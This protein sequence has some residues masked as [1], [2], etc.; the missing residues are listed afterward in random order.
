M[1][2]EESSIQGVGAEM[3]TESSAGL[4]GFQSWKL[5]HILGLDNNLQGT[6]RKK[7]KH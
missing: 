7:M 5:K 2:G 6:A 3:A 1:E 4:E